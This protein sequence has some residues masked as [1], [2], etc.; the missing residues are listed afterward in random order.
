MQV[1]LEDCSRLLYRKELELE[2]KGYRPGLVEMALERARS[3]AERKVAPIKHG[4]IR[5]A[6][7]HD[8]LQDE[9]AGAEG[10]MDGVLASLD[11]GSITQDTSRVDGV[12]QSAKEGGDYR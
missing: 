2:A 6:A 9:L 5:L 12:P 11:D 4:D 10:W 1:T 3:T 8:I 7:F